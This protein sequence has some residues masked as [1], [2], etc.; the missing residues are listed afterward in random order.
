MFL[1]TYDTLNDL[2]GYGNMPTSIQSSF[3]KRSSQKKRRKLERQN[4][5]RRRK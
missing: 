3:I 1:D 2:M 5:K 4:P